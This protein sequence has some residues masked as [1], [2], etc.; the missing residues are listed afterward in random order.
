MIIKT[1]KQ[2]YFIIFTVVYDIQKPTWL[3]DYKKKKKRER[4][5][6]GECDFSQLK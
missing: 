2:F 3:N 6:I 4:E 1:F 5:R